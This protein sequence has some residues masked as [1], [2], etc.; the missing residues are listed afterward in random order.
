MD[1]GLDGRVA[2][3]TG[4]GRGLGRAMVLAL[5]REGVRVVA[6]ARSLDELREVAGAAGDGAVEMVICDVAV[7][8]QVEG[9]VPR[10]LERFGDLDVVVNNAGIAPAGDFLTQDPAIWRRAFEVNAIAPGLLARTAARHFVGKR[11]GKVINVASTTGVRGKPQLAA[12]SAS[13]G[14]LLRMTEAL[15]AEWAEHGIQVNAIAPG[16]FATRAQRAV[17]EDSAL[18]ERR[19]RRI[20]QRRFAS[21]DEIG[22]LACYLASPRSAFVTGAVFVIDGGEAAKL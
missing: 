3:V 19:V 16:A 21:P 9:L 4:A 5:V 11:A 8:D 20:P 2:I 6:A 10:A 17:L 22:E 15:S 14:A 12:Y 13:K 7:P 18:H 1:L